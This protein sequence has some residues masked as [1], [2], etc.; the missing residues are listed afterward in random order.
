MIEQAPFLGKFLPQSSGKILVLRHTLPSRGLHPW[1]I[2]GQLPMTRSSIQRLPGRG[3]FYI[4]LPCLEFNII[5]RDGVIQ[6]SVRQTGYKSF[7]PAWMFQSSCI[8]IQRVQS[9]CKT[10]MGRFISRTHHNSL[11]FFYIRL[12]STHA[13][14]F[15]EQYVHRIR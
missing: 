15:C 9:L 8:C 12:I 6:S 14:L 3:H 13:D 7:N 4:P 5:F 1:T 2:L 11:R 10:A